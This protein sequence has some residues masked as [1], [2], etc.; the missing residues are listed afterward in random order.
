M[1]HGY[2]RAPYIMPFD[3]RRSFQSGLFGSKP[4][5][6][7]AQIRIAHNLSTSAMTHRRSRD[8]RPYPGSRNAVDR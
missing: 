3:H 4:P 5:L 6:S 2:D 8:T 7:E 1:P